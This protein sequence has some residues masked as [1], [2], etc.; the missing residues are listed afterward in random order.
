M[1]QHCSCDCDTPREAYRGDLWECPICG[2]QFRCRITHEEYDEDEE[3]I[4]QNP[5]Y[6]AAEWILVVFCTEMA[7]F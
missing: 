3:D 2:C 5:G 1:E 4:H 6:G 7:G